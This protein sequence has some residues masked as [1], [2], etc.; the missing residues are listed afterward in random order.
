MEMVGPEQQDDPFESSLASAEKDYHKAE[1]IFFTA[2]ASYSEH[3]SNENA[4]EIA[5]STVSLLTEFSSYV[6]AILEEERFDD[7]DRA[8]CIA[9]LMRNADEKRVLAFQELTGNENFK[10]ANHERTEDITLDQLQNIDKVQLISEEGEII[11]EG[12]SAL[13]Q[14]ITASYS[15]FLKYDLEILDNL[16]PPR[17]I[18]QSNNTIEYETLKSRAEELGT[19]AAGTAIGGVIAGLVLRRFFK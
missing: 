1:D 13:T 9:A 12:K 15:Q 17:S 7:A 19:I 3:P 11:D 14:I 18:V 5:E 16:I 2:S 4:D 6:D 8:S 10:P